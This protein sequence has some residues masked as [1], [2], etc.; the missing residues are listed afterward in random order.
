MQP[1]WTVI[2]ILEG[3]RSPSTMFLAV[4]SR[5]SIALSIA[6]LILATAATVESATMES[7]TLL[8][9]VDCPGN[10]PVTV[11]S[12]GTVYSRCTPRTSGASVLSI[13][14]A[15]VR[16]VLTSDQCYIVS[17]L[18]F[19]ESL[20]MLFAACGQ[21][22][23][24]GG[25]GGIYSVLA[26]GTV[27]YQ[28]E[29]DPHISVPNPSHVAWSP[30]T[31]RLYYRG[32]CLFRAANVRVSGAVADSIT[33]YGSTPEE[34]I[35]P[36]RRDLHVSM[37]VSPLSVAPSDTVYLACD[38][39][40]GLL[41]ISYSSYSGVTTT[42]YAGL[43]DQN[44]VSIAATLSGDVFLTCAPRV[45]VSAYKGNLMQA[46]ESHHPG[47]AASRALYSSPHVETCADGSNNPFIVYSRSTDTLYLSCDNGLYRR[48]A[49]DSGFVN[50]NSWSRS[51]LLTTLTSRVLTNTRDTVYTRNEISGI[52][53]TYRLTVATLVGGGQSQALA[54]STND[55]LVSIPV[56][57]FS[58]NIVITVLDLNNVAA[59]VRRITA[60]GVCFESY[61]ITYIAAVAGSGRACAVY[62]SCPP[63][64]I[65]TVIII[66]DASSALSIGTALPSSYSD[67]SLCP[68]QFGIENLVASTSGQRL[69]ASCK[70]ATSII[71]YQLSVNPVTVQLAVSSLPSSCGDASLSYVLSSDGSTLYA[72]CSSIYAVALTSAGVQTGAAPVNLGT[73][74][75]CAG[76]TGLQWNL[77]F[78]VLY[79]TCATDAT[80][81]KMT[82]ANRATSTIASF[83]AAA[84]ASV[85]AIG[86]A[87]DSE[88]A[89][90]SCAKAVIALYDG[91]TSTV[92]TGPKAINFDPNTSEFYFGG[93]LPSTEVSTL[94]FSCGRVPG[95]EVINSACTKCAAGRSRSFADT[96]SGKIQQCTRCPG[97]SIAALSGALACD[98]C[99]QGFFQPSLVGVPA[100]TCFSCSP[101]SFSN[102]TGSGSCTDCTDGKVAAVSQSTV[103][104]PCPRG[105]Y[106]SGLANVR[107]VVCA[108]V[109]L[110]CDEVSNFVNMDCFL[111]LR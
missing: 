3:Q 62:I 103:C 96:A 106:A 100:V 49:S 70:F 101:G 52:E 5:F 98:A 51:N 17:S 57:G 68:S 24:S 16:T 10:Y 39:Y 77:A 25:I 61:E 22:A 110:I 46:P 86:V 48:S 9:A 40:V 93:L 104:D 64:L 45:V 6:A 30:Y 105:S 56:F 79:V 37:E 89:F 108:Q 14:G 87:Y 67:S 2:S 8:A 81:I 74:V 58:S 35:C 90:V 109:S 31:D 34:C 71:M 83:S 84:C 85:T 36:N 75:Q 4:P 26:D 23:S 97:G 20:Q 13:N 63:I 27:H 11:T 50:V 88:A 60:A 7:L 73:G 69:Y 78:T 111:R 102:N 21:K 92:T 15:I 41:Q 29:T 91:R 28:P 18:A 53:A 55:W 54:R 65:P 95:F 32:G 82:V 76:P 72:G 42:S 107:C 66:P 12:S 43:C 33:L 94:S 44:I 47:P 38:A 19:A 99:D 1:S 59:G 80:V